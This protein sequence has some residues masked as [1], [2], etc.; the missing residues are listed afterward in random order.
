M[1]PWPPLATPQFS[2]RP[3]SQRPWQLSAVPDFPSRPSPGTPGSM[4][5][6]SRWDHRL[7][8]IAPVCGQS[9]GENLR[10]G[11]VGGDHGGHLGSWDQDPVTTGGRGR[12]GLSGPLPCS[13]L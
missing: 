1:G 6:T 3:T 7:L 12:W 10:T 13:R 11:V 4:G 8:P 2:L 5:P 9:R